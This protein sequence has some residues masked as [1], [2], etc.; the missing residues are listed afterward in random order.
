MEAGMTIVV[1]NFW[2]KCALS[3]LHDCDISKI[4]P[5]MH[6]R[7]APVEYPRRQAEASVFFS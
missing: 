4:D 1:P 3:A 2:A 6:H 5:T 7:S